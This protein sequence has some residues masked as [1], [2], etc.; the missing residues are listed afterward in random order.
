MNDDFQNLRELYLAAGV[1]PNKVAH[2]M[3]AT[4]ALV[5][6]GTMEPKVIYQAQ[7]IVAEG[8]HV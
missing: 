2:L 7:A 4:A 1:A 5:L 6:L 3:K 8:M